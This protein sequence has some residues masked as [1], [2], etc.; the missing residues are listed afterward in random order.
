M[1]RYR[2]REGQPGAPGYEAVL[3]EIVARD[4]IDSGRALAPLKPA[5]DAVRLDTSDR[6]FDAQVAFI[7]STVEAWCAGHAVEASGN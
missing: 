7:V 4:R 5:E 6:T 1:R 3:Q 2:E